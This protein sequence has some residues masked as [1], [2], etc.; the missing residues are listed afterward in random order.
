MDSANVHQ[1]GMSWLIYALITVS[2]W[3]LYGNL[4]HTGQLGMG[5]PVN[6]RYK[7][8]LFVGVAYFFTAILAPIITLLVNHADWNLPMKGVSWSL[9]AG[10]AGA[11]GAFGILL[12]FGARGT[13][14][15][16][17]SI[18]FAG[19]PIVNAIVSMALHP[20][21]GGLAG[22][23]WQFVAGILLAALGGC[24]VTL[25]KPPAGLPPARAA[26]HGSTNPGSR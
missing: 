13:P 14:P 18:V 5:D 20:P 11:L 19:A 12:A 9:L 26:V 6:G 8:F 15:V 17:M 3:G 7:A 23:R 25:Y 4:L 1:A 2:A 21:A 16:V 22:V 10:C 24:M